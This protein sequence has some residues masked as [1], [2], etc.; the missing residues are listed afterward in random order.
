MRRLPLLAVLVVTLSAGA[1]AQPEGLQP[2]PRPTASPAVA[3]DRPTLPPEVRASEGLTLYDVVGRTQAEVA[4][5]MQARTPIRHADG[6]PRHLAYT[7]FS[8]HWTYRVRP[9]ASG[10]R[11]QT[12][13]VR[14]E[15]T[16]TRPRW[17]PPPDAEP[18]ALRWWAAFDDALAR[19]EAGHVNYNRHAARAIAE[20]L[21]PM[22]A[23]TCGHLRRNA[24]AAAQTVYDR[25]RAFNAAYDRATDH[26]ATQ[27]RDLDPDG[28]A[29]D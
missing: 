1:S 10:C 5:S 9:F 18:A 8:L 21:R 23:G 14:L 11:V 25:Y 3:P 29:S 28:A 22:W 17:T 15:Q 19:H 7:A 13:E 20:A 6:R 12:V 4:A 26:G 27:R 16:V 24:D 2:F